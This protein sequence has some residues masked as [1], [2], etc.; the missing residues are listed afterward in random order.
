MEYEDEEEDDGKMIWLVLFDVI[1][2]L[3]ILFCRFSVGGVCMVF[4]VFMFLGF[5]IFFM[6]GYVLDDE[7]SVENFLFLVENI[8]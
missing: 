5:V 8:W 2:L 1:V 7:E 6:F 4:V 3:G